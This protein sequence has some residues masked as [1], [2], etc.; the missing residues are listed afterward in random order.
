[1]IPSRGNGPRFFSPGAAD[2]IIL[3]ITSQFQKLVQK[4]IWD[5]LISI[6]FITELNG[7]IQC[8]KSI[9]WALGA[10]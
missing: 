10:K 4:V 2:A 6:V 9:F 7:H 8:M 1:M 3:V 5:K